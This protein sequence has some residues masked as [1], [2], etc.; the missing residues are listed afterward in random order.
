MAVNDTRYL[1]TFDAQETGSKVNTHDLVAPYTVTVTGTGTWTCKIQQSNDNS[2]W[3]TVGVDFTAA[4]TQVISSAAN[5]MRI[6]CTARS[7][8]SAVV[9][10]SAPLAA[11]QTNAADDLTAGLGLTIS[12][13]VVDVG[14]GEGL[15]ASADAFDV[16]WAN[17]TVNVGTVSTAGTLSTVARGDHVH[18]LGTSVLG[19]STADIGAA[20]AGGSASTVSKSDHVHALGTAVYGVSTADIGGTSAAGSAATIS[21]SDHVHALGASVYGAS[22]AD[23]G[24]ASAAGSAATVSKSDHVHA[25]GTGVYGVSTAD[26]GLAS[27][28]GS[29]TTVSKSDH[30][31]AL[32]LSVVGG[33]NIKTGFMPVGIFSGING[34]GA[35]TF[36]G[37]SAGDVVQAVANMTS[38]VDG[39]ASFEA[40][41]TVDG[42]IKQEDAADLSTTSFLAFVLK[43][44]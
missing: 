30:V 2:S 39:A 18:A 41:I 4:G 3:V 19:V 8:G 5:Y 33:P 24:A 1:G 17:S 11:N 44:N 27:A 7:S 6:D 26:V 9:S 21:K 36:A 12:G 29:A 34:S 35:V 37:V 32:A 38:A 20:S 16:M 23:I 14:A 43:R 15:S 22:T 25:L 28:A 42:Q 13:R 40:A 10:V 31:H